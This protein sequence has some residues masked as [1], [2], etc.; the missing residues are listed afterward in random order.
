MANI[1]AILSN[2]DFSSPSTWFGN[3]V[4][5]PDD[6]A[7]ANGNTVL[8]SDTRTVQAISNAVGTG[9]ATGGTFSLVN[10]CNLNCTNANGI[11]QGTTGTSCVT[12]ASLGVGSEATLTAA[13]TSTGT[14]TT[15]SMSGG[16]ALTALG[17]YANGS[18]GFTLTITAGTVN[19]TG[20]VTGG[21]E[22]CIVLSAAGGTLIQTGDVTGGG[23]A[24]GSGI[25]MAA[26]T[27]VIVTGTV[28]G[29]AG[30][31]GITTPTTGAANLTINGV[32]RSSATFPPVSAGSNTQNTF[33]SGP[34]QM[35]LSGNINPLQVQ[36][37]V[38][39]ST[40]I[41]SSLEIARYD[42]TT[43]RLLYT[44]DNM[45]SGGYPVI[46][47]VRQSTVY[48]PSS[49]F[50]GTLAIPSPSSVALGVPTDNTTGTAILTAASIRSAMG[51]ASANLDAQ[52]SNKATVDQVASIVQGATSA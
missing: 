47:N 22:R 39:A 28:T 43:R 40:L 30:S 5:G 9:I 8:V 52:M 6:V 23:G 33:L 19:H 10:G 37:W 51:M 3:V 4:P 13:V 15:I 14:A 18:S 46:A 41:P 26:G 31:P 27:T 42:G 35:G 34:F 44:A 12:T 32:C 24:S 49:E 36:R 17:N 45:P 38:W 20:S 29:G 11:I 25:G 7:F 48:G 21:G 50:T 1:R 2:S 16:G